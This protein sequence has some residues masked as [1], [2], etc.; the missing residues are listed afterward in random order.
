VLAGCRSAGGGVR[1][2]VQFVVATLVPGIAVQLWELWTLGARAYV[3]HF[4]AWQAYLASESSGSGLSGVLAAIGPDG[5]LFPRAFVNGN[6]A[7]AYF[8]GAISATAI[9]VLTATIA[10]RLRGRGADGD[11]PRG[12][13][14]IAGALVWTAL[15]VHAGWWV[16]LSSRDWINHL[17][18]A[19]VYLA[20]A[21]AVSLAMKPQR[22]LTIATWTVVLTVAI[23]RLAF[24]ASYIPV[25][26]QDPKIHSAMEVR[27]LLLS[28]QAK[29]DVLVA[30]GWW[31]PRDL[32][33]LLPSVGNF[34]DCFGMDPVTVAEGR[35]LLV[36]NVNFWNWEQNPSMQAFADSCERT[37][38]FRNAHYVLSRCTEPPGHPE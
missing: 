2:S 24:L 34:R 35:S 10:L 9:L 7:I 29:G 14:R 32:E 25:F 36:R 16:L 17:L 4:A 12:E 23:P 22:S 26:S 33:Y 18:P 6:V 13:Q 37:I 21:F 30:C 27:D 19:F 15:I 5:A 38:Q 31:V 3:D 11:P 1:R 28:R 20:A 8:G